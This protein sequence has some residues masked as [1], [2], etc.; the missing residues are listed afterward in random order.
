MSTAHPPASPSPGSG[1]SQLEPTGVIHDLGYRGYNG[2]LRSDA[3]I[4]RALFVQGLRSI[5]GLGRTGKA[6]FLPFALL[7]FYLFPAI[8][9]VGIL[10]FGLLPELPIRLHDYALSYSI[11]SSLF[12]ATQAP[13]LFSS[14]LRTRAIVLYLARPLSAATF[15]LMRC[16][17]MAVGT[18]LF[19]MAPVA[20]MY[21]GALLTG[22][23]A[24]PL[25]TQLWLAVVMGLIAAAGLAALAGVISS[26]TLRPGLAIVA[27][28]GV[29]L[30]GAGVVA[31]VQAIS[32]QLETDIYGGIAGLFSPFSL[33]AGLGHTL[34]ENVAVV[35]PIGSTAMTALYWAVAVLGPVLGVLLIQRRFRKEVAR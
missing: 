16:A 12:V 33:A 3:A 20:L 28:T 30:L 24:G 19:L 18:F 26:W 14:D 8:I 17:S 25:S 34:D 32:I 10:S 35:Q 13:V 23:D 2:G 4:A 27:I 15:A 7:V 29:L 21:I 22:L 31:L 11:L 9:V 1:S 6:K 5:Y